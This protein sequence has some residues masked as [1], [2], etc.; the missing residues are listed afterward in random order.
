MLTANQ[1]GP[2][3]ILLTSDRLVLYLLCFFPL[4]CKAQD[5]R[6]SVTESALNSV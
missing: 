3:H 6:S 2:T 1:H 5:V 4:Y